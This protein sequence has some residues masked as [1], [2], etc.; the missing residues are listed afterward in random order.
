MKIKH[1]PDRCVV[2][3]GIADRDVVLRPATE[4]VEHVFAVFQNSGR[5]FIQ[6]FAA[7][8]FALELADGFPVQFDVPT[9][10]DVAVGEA[11]CP[12]LAGC[13]ELKSDAQVKAAG[14]GWGFLPLFHDVVAQVVIL[15][16]DGG[17]GSGAGIPCGRDQQGDGK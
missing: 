4:D 14:L 1:L 2:D 10:V 15:L 12:I 5:Q 9:I 6:V 7:L 13:L 8:L 17:E 11:Q 16:V 3:P